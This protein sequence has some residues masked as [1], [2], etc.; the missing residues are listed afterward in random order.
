MWAVW[1]VFAA[2][3]SGYFA[4]TKTG[5]LQTDPQL[6][7]LQADPPSFKL[8]FKIKESIGICVINTRGIKRKGIKRKKIILCA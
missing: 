2:A 4:V 3:E 8:N 5:I 1:E 6:K 7:T